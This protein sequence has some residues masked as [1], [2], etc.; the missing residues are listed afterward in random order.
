MRRFAV[1][2]LR[3]LGHH[4]IEA[5]DAEEAIPMLD[6]SPSVS[7]LFSDIGLPGMDGRARR[8]MSPPATPDRILLTT[9]Y[10]NLRDGA[11]PGDPDLDP[12][13]KPYTVAQL[14]SRASTPFCA[15]RKEP[16]AS[17]S[18]SLHNGASDDHPEQ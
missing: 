16:W 3:E 10:A 6:E 17:R 18:V 8:A 13:P 5:G 15:S 12:L 2:A 7:L 4:V 14:Q 1:E 11:G 9:G